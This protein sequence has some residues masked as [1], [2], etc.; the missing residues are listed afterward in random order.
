MLGCNLVILWLSLFSIASYMLCSYLKL[1]SVLMRTIFTWTFF[2][3]FVSLF[4]AMLLV[5]Y[6][7]LETKGNYY[8]DENKCYWNEENSVCDI[9]SYK[10]Y[11]DL[12]ADYSLSDKR[13]CD[14]LIRNEGCRFVLQ[15]EIIHGLFCFIMSI[16]IMYFY[17]FDF[18][19]LYIYLSSIVFSSIQFALITWYLVTVFVEMYFVKNEKLWWCPLLWN[20]PWVIV[21]QYIIYFA[22]K[23]IVKNNK[24]E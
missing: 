9:F 19:K 17:F 18:N 1:D 12:Y 21:P 5:Y 3:M 22:I 7:Y 16:I 20:V 15:G 24:L 10:M 8:Y 6:K 13:Y 11:M 2:M 14:N 23:E 4:E